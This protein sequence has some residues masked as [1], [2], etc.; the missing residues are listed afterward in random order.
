MEHDVSLVSKV[1]TMMAVI[2]KA[3]ATCRFSVM[4]QLTNQLSLFVSSTIETAYIYSTSLRFVSTVPT[5]H[6]IKNYFKA[7]GRFGYM[8]L[9][10]T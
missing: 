10:P 8:V 2:S 9:Q 5:G 1:W 3:F 4:W 7:P 6:A